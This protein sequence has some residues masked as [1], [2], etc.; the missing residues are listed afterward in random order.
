MTIHYNGGIQHNAKGNTMQTLFI[1]ALIAI[2]YE[3]ALGNAD[4]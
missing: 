2:V 4:W 1:I 3:A